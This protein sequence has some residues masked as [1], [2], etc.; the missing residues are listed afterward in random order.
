MN[1]KDLGADFVFAWPQAQ[2]GVTGGP[3]ETAA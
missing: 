1:S 2:I 3:L